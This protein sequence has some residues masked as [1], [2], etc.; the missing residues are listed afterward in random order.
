MSRVELEFKPTELTQAT[1]LAG[2]IRMLG[3][4]IELANNGGSCKGILLECD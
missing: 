4:E 1:V 3:I 2:H